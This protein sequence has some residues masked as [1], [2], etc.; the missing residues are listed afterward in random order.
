[1]PETNL[2]ASITIKT[3]MIKRNIPRVRMV[4]GKVS[5]IRSGLTIAFNIPRTN[6]KIKAVP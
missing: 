3:L 2:P 6:T 4:I 1:M 5:I